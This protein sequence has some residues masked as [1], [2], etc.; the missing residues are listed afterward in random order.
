VRNTI[1]EPRPH[2]RIG[3]VRESSIDCTAFYGIRRKHPHPGPWRSPYR[4][5]SRETAERVV[6]EC[7]AGPEV[8][9]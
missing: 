3:S 6:A 4:H 7:F 1:S 8:H 2:R 9:K 5:S